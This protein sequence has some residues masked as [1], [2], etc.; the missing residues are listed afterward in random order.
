MML[1]SA[2]YR[3][4]V[5]V[6]AKI[7]ARNQYISQFCKNPLD[8]ENFTN[9]MFRN[10]FRHKLVIDAVAKYIGVYTYDPFKPKD[11]SDDTCD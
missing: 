3:V 10:K 7:K 9:K 8:F 11:A 4:R 2:M 5:Y 1:I 6:V